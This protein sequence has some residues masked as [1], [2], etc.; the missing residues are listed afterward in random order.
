MV[1]IVIPMAG[2]GKRFAEAGYDIPKPFIDV[3]G[4]QMIRR[5]IENLLVP[6]VTITFICR[7]EHVKYFDDLSRLYD[8]N[9]LALNSKTEGAV[10][11]VLRAEHLVN[12]DTPLIIANCD[13]LILQLSMSDF[14]RKAENYDG[15]A[16][17]FNSTNPHHSYMRLHAGEVVEVAEKKVISDNAVAGI[18]YYKKGSEFVKYA[19]QMIKKNIRFN[20]EFYI[21]PVFNEFLLD[22]KH[23]GT[24]E[25]SVNNK[26]MLGTPE[27]L[28]IFLD[29][30]EDGRVKL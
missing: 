11:T 26:H 1:N 2:E 4:K 29:K 17:T 7:S 12:N 10:C 13:Q 28:K 24:Y 16:I 20:N 19:K 9:I 30:V 18:Y 15:F 21:S 27:E 23:L 5:V 3:A 25:V 14:L 6:E 22:G 8:I